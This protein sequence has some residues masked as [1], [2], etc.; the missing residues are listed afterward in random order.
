M[1]KICAEMNTSAITPITWKLRIGS[2]RD[3]FWELQR[4]LDKE[5]FKSDKTFEPLK[6]EPTPIEGHATFS[7]NIEGRK[8]ILKSTR[9]R[10]VLGIILCFTIILILIGL[11]LIGKSAYEVTQEVKINLE[12]ETYRASARSQDPYKPQSEVT[13]TVSNARVLLEGNICRRRGDGKI[14]SASVLEVQ[15]FDTKVSRIEERLNKLIP[16]IKLPDVA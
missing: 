7:G 8:N 10:F 2:P 6:L 11:W 9:W 15:A 1:Q 3:L 5:G 13:D 4:F 16:S 14:K 12:G